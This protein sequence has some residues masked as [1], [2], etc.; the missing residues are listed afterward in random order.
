[1][2]GPW[3]NT[4]SRAIWDWE[5]HFDIKLVEKLAR[6][7]GEARPL[8]SGGSVDWEWVVDQRLAFL[9]SQGEQLR[10][11]RYPDLTTYQQYR[12][13]AL[14]AWW[15]S[16]SV[17]GLKWWQRQPRPPRGLLELAAVTYMKAVNQ[18][19]EPLQDIEQCASSAG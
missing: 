13:R 3:W 2:I 4:P 16:R 8:V 17:D 19:E 12:L 1:M 15:D 5:K 14:Q 9:I 7:Q 11:D 18:H 10:P 6:A